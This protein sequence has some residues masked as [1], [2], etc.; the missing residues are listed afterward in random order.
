MTNKKKLIEK[1]I[2]SPQNLK[3]SEI[4]TLFNNDEHIIEWGKWSHKII[5]NIVKWTSITIPIHNND[6]IT[7]YKRK[8]RKFYFNNLK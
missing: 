3:Y 5:S 8:L 2:N 6:C 7:I 4:E 1:L